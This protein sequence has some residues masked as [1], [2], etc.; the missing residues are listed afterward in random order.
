M[1]A[2]TTTYDPV[3]KELYPQDE[4]ER[5]AYEQSPLVGMI[6]KRTDF[7]GRKA[8]LPLRYGT[9]QSLGAQFTIAQG[10]K[11]NNTYEAFE[12]TR[13]KYYAFAYLDREAMLAT[14]SNKGAFVEALEGEIDGVLDSVASEFAFQL[15][16][17]HGGTRARMTSTSAPT[18][19]VSVTIT[20]VYDMVNFEVGM[21]VVTWG[22]DTKTTSVDSGSLT[23]TA[24][25][26]ANGK[27]KGAASWKSTITTPASSDYIFRYGDKGRCLYGLDDWVPSTATLAT[28]MFGVNRAL[29]PERLGGLRK[30]ASGMTIEE[31]LIDAATYAG[32]HKAAPDVCILNTI[33]WGMLEKELGSKIVRDIVKSTRA[34]IGYS[35]IVLQGPKGPIKVVADPYCPYKTG[36]LLTLSTWAFYGLGP[37]PTIIQDDDQKMLRVYNADQYEIRFGW[38]GQLGCTAP[39]KNVRIGF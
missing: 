38:I 17:H 13:G 32:F 16:H 21:K 14:A 19:A 33:R 10:I 7:Y 6:K 37:C 4:V 23:I 2:T 5:L 28:T 39:G 18:T 22:A 31:V 27:I 30:S 29:D 9:N 24:L 25:D 3:L 8:I 34:D 15:Y 35:A 36:W 20:N 11:H 26:R 12:I 1:S